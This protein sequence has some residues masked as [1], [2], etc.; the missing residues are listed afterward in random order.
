MAKTKALSDNQRSVLGFI[1]MAVIGIALYMATLDEAVRP[2]AYVYAILGG[3]VVV[4]QL[5]K[6]QLGVRDSTTAA[7]SKTTNASLQQFRQPSS[8]QIG[9]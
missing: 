4:A 9:A 6:D 7:V 1:T 5:A 3:I 2:P 8:E